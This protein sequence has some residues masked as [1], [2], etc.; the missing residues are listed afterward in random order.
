LKR[1]HERYQ[2]RKPITES[3]FFKSILYAIIGC[4]T[5]P[6]INLFNRLKIEGMEKLHALPK[7]GVLFVS[8]H[9][10]YFTDVITFIHIFCAARRGKGKRLGFPFYLFF[11]FT[12]IKYVAAATTMR[13]TFMSR[14]FTLAGAITV[15]RT[16]SEASGETRTGL[17]TSDIRTVGAALEKNWVITFPQGTTTPYA[18]GRKG[19]AFIIKQYRPIVVPIVIDGFSEAFSKTGLKL[20]KRRTRLSVRIKDP[21]VID[22]DQS[23]EDMLHQIMEAIEQVPK[24]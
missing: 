1:S 12:R 21:L 23:N 20:K 9:Q 22:Y 15:K 3:G 19:T 6:G 5:Y 11:P 17:E 16:W 7:R 10:T 2:L 18:P 13:S 24:Q 14:L 4:Y 8:N